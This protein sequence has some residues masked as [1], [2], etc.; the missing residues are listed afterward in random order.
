MKAYWG[1]EVQLHAFLISA[2][3]GGELWASRP[4]HFTPRERAL[5]IHWIGGRVGPRT[6]HDAVEKRKIPSPYRDSNPHP[7]I[8]PVAQCYAT[9]L[10]SNFF[11]FDKFR[12]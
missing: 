9:E 3:D 11:L 6:G 4:G 1:V 12:G 7:I 5:G 2:L 8:Q 10:L